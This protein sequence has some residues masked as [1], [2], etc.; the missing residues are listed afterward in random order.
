MLLIQDISYINK[1]SVFVSFKKL[2]ETY[3]GKGHARFE[4]TEFFLSLHVRNDANR[5]CIF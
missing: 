3:I 2:I 5:T 1:I 4:I